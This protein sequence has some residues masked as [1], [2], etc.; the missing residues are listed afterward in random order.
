MIKEL[1][2]AAAMTFTPAAA[3]PR[4][5]AEMTWEES[6]DAG[7]DPVRVAAIMYTESRYNPRA[8]NRRSRTRG[9]MQV[10]PF[11]LRYFNLRPRQLFNP[12]INIESGIQILKIGETAHHERCPRRF[13]RRYDRHHSALAHYR[14]HRDGLRSRACRRSVRNVH[15]WE[16]RLRDRVQEIERERTEQ[17]GGASEEN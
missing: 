9:L 17:D 10:A 15:R 11:W 12:R 14:C 6:Q 4:E 3:M 7:V 5:Y 13:G 1:F 16:Q 8:F 2:L